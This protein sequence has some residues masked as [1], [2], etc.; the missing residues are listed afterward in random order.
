M[1][2]R[3]NVSCRL[4]FTD[5]DSQISLFRRLVSL[6]VRMLASVHYLLRTQAVHSPLKTRPNDLQPFMTK[7]LECENLVCRLPLTDPDV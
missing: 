3:K 7:L 5:P 4:S 2:Q 6:V 1:L